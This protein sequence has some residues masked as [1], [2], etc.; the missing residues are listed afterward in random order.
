MLIYFL[1]VPCLLVLLWSLIH[2]L[3]KTSRQWKPGRGER[4]IAGGLSVRVLGT[5]EPVYVLLHGLVASGDYFGAIYDALAARGT[6]VVPD[7]LGFGRSLHAE[8]NSY[9]LEA[10]LDALDRMMRELGLSGRP[11]VIAG[12][13]MGGIIAIHWAARH[14]E[15]TE[16]VITF[17]SPLYRNEEEARAHIQ[18]MGIIERLFAMD[19]TFARR[20]CAWMCHYRRLAGW[21]AV[22]MFPRF[23]VQ[24]ARHA[25][26]HTW[27]TYQGAMQGI[28][29][30]GGW[31]ASLASL[32]ESNVRLDMVTAGNDHATVKGLAQHLAERYQNIKNTEH[33]SARHELPLSEPRWCLSVLSEDS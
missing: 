26:L 24:V 1:A 29:L 15:R 4:S 5:G 16:R 14:R 8:T 12:H 13:S 3:T 27:N 7:L 25:V 31:E 28:I 32:Q 2:A 9:G 10:H 22:A 23:P 33:P 18:A 6:L 17:C 11:M 30:Q 21:L 20:V 19:G